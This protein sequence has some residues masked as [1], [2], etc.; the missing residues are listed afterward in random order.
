MTNTKPEWWPKNPYP[1]SVFPMNL[2]R[3]SDIV[4]DPDIR[5][6]LS[7]ALGRLF[8]DIASDAIWEALAVEIEEETMKHFVDGDQLVITQNDFVNLQE[9]PAV[10]YSLD[11]D[12]ARTVLAKGVPM[13]PLSDLI[14]ISRELAEAESKRD[15]ETA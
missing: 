12:V 11:S 15:I 2:E 8:W 9:S 6:A 13:L 10:F 4:P 3:Y 7:G 14:R 1:I 5:T